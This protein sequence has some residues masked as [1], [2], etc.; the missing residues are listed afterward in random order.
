[1]LSWKTR[2]IQIREVAAGQGVGYS[3]GYVTEFPTRVA[4]LA[5][6]YSDGLSRQLSSRGRVI[7]RN[8]YASIIGNVSMNY[9][10]VD[11]TGIGGVEVGDEVTIIGETAS[12]KIS[13]WEHANLAGTIPYEILCGISSRLPRKYVE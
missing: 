8:D 10:A 6:G 2:I 12:R 1:V 11:V 13:A 4:V 9:T 3:S 5:V 7:I